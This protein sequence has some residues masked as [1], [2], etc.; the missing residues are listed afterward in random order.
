MKEYNC[1]KCNKLCQGKPFIS[2]D[3]KTKICY[4]CSMKEI[5]EIINQFLRPKGGK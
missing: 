5:A 4:D 2:K 1:E 3:K